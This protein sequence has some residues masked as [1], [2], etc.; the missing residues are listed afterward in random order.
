MSAGDIRTR[1]EAPEDESFVRR[2]IEDTVA[3]QLG[4]EAWPAELRS[5][6]L[7]MQYAA[8]RQAMRSG[9]PEGESRILLVDGQPAGWLYAAALPGEIRLVE[10][11]VA[12][13]H[14]G[15]GIGTAVLGKLIR[16]ARQAGKPLRL[17]VDV[18]NAGAIR[19]YERAG[20]HRTGGDAVQ[21]FLEH[22][23]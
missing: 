23:V 10:I 11:M 18:R 2:L 16:T 12:A 20:F 14:R 21:H 5:R 4:A 15:R 7:G 3:G 9:Y 17:S 1:T 22:A 6:I 8:R 13:Q 19:L